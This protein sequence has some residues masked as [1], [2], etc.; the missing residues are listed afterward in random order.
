MSIQLSFDLPAPPA[1]AET[2]L[3]PV[4]MVNEWVFCPRLAFLE[5]VDGEWADSGD[6]EEGR[7]A[8]VRVDAGGGRL[9]AAEAVD[10]KPDFTVRAVTLASETLGIIA[11]MDLVEGEDGVVTP[12]DTKKGKRPHVAEGAYAPE[13]VQVCAQA[14]ILEDAGYRVTEGAIWY[15]GSRERVRI[16][17]DAELRAETRTAISQL[18][19]AAAAGKLPPPLLDNPKCTKCS[20]AGICLPDEV[21]FFR[22]GLAPRPLN[23]SAD[24]AL[25]LYVQEPGARVRKSGETLVIETDDVKTEVPIGEV[26]EL[27]LHGPV[28][29]TGPTVTALLRE[30][31]PVTWASAG[32]WVLG[33]TVSTGHRNVN[34][35]I[36][37]Y[38]AAFDER[39]ALGFARTLVAA[40][41]RNARVFLRRNF[42]AGDEAA[43]DGALEAMARLADRALHAPTEAELLGL[44][45][46]AAARYF[47]LFDTMLGDAA[48]KFPQFAFEKRTR[49]PPAD[50]VNAMLSFGYALLTR[51][52]HT[53]LSGVGFDPYLG[54]YHKP[55]F[56]R[57]AL[58]LDMMEPFR[59]ILADSTVIQVINNGEVK[60]DG[61]TA[62]GPAV[63]LKPAAKRAFIAAY[64]RRLD[65]EV[66]HPVFGYRVAMRRL[67]EVQAR[68]LARHLAGEIDD[69]PHYLV[70]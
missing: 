40:K 34:I 29:V 19:L 3:V 55:R 69:Y 51:T 9:P 7:R 46:E 65:Q 70:R 68:L 20:L 26:S 64:E 52:W 37:Q 44:E 57:A 60:P 6:T 54:F 5:W 38:R 47:R 41:I 8:H 50:P 10:D 24:A 53:V 39:R 36:A 27:V 1:T 13:R 12:I 48:Q 15:A 28:S 31:I 11:K 14:L 23:P 35:R 58:A 25:P 42:K 56:G 66:T 45:G 16:G 21:S 43:R 63:T 17:L 30:E 61:F 67:L 4:R 33:H 22:K 49:R 18:R 2:P 32:G 59:P 62:A